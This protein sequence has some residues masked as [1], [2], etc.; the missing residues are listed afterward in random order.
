LTANLIASFTS[1]TEPTVPINIPSGVAVVQFFADA[2]N[3]AQGWTLH[4]S[5][6]TS[7][8]NQSKVM[9]NMSVMPNP[10]NSYSQL[11]FTLTEN[12]DTKIYVTNMLGEIV[13]TNEY[14]LT[15]GVHEFPMNEIFNGEPKSGI[16]FI[17][18]DSGNEIRTQKFVVL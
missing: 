17:N 3:I 5:S 6:S 9:S 16:Y 4:Y 2:N 13:S 12:N 7:D 15:D 18:V 14:C 1:S 8:I 10:G 11:V